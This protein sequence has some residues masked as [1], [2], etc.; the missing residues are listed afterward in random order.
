MKIAIVLRHK[1][2]LDGLL[3]QI[4]LLKHRSH[5][6]NVFLEED[7]DSWASTAFQAVD[8]FKPHVI[9]TWNGRFSWYENLFYEFQKA[10]Y[11]VV[12]SERAW[13]PQKGFHFI[14]DLED[15]FHKCNYKIRN[16]YPINEERITR[17]KKSYALAPR[18]KMKY[19]L[20]PFQIESDTSI[21]HLSTYI[22]TNQSLIV[23]AEQ[24]FPDA[25]LV[26]SKHPLR[27]DQ[28]SSISA[29]KGKLTT[30]QLAQAAEYVVAINSTVTIET[31]LW[32]GNVVIFGKNPAWQAMIDGN[33]GLDKPVDIQLRYRVLSYLLNRQ[34]RCDKKNERVAKFIEGDPNVY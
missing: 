4:D 10:G 1:V 28:P 25:H 5:R 23:R 2:L 31:L 32:H 26:A 22:K 33:K 29:Y 21:S 16:D 8:K 11:R 20:I 30:L 27:P 15:T 14:C 34:Y 9:W 6:V 18:P 12:V 17:L 19:I 24:L 7:E 13:L 3:P